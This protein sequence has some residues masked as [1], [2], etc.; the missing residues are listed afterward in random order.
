MDYSLIANRL[1][2]STSSKFGESC[3][4]LSNIVQNLERERKKKKKKKKKRCLFRNKEE[5]CY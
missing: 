3:K 5:C 1:Q 4:F 2:D